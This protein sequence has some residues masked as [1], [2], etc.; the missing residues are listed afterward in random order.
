MNFTKENASEKEV[1]AEKPKNFNPGKEESKKR[2]KLEKLESKIA[3]VEEELEQL[4]DELNLP[5]NA[6]DYTLLQEIQS[7]I[8]EN[9]E[10]LLNL[11]E[12][13]EEYAS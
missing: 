13:W 9:E 3:A 8:D 7:K 12:E 6:S 4:K 2:R 1:K 11:M 5:Q 10:E